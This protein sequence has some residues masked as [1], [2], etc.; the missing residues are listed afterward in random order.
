MSQSEVA[1]EGTDTVTL[2][3]S[4]RDSSLC[5]LFAEH[6]LRR[7]DALAVT[8][9]PVTLTYRQLDR[10]TNSLASALRELGVG[11]D[12]LVTI[13]ADRSLGVVVGM[14]ATVKAGGAYLAL[15]PTQPATRLR[16]ILEEAKPVAL[17]TEAGADD[18]SGIGTPVV[19]IADHL[20]DAVRD[21]AAHDVRIDGG[22]GP[23][24]L[25]YVVYTSGSTGKPKGICITHRNVVQRTRHTDYLTFAPGDRVAQVSNAAFDATTI[26]VWG[27]L[28]NGA[29]LIGF[30]RD[31]ILSPGRLGI[32]L[33]EHHI[34]TMVIPTPLFNQLAA[35]DPSTFATVS[36]I[37]VGG[38]VIGVGQANSVA[39]L[40]GC[41]LLNGYGPAECTTLATAHRV[42]PKPADQLRV[43]IG[44]PISNTTCYVLDDEL[45]P[46][47]AGLPGQLYI[48]GDGVARGYLGR[49]DLTKER[50]LPDP[51]AAQPGA[52][53]YATGDLV[54]QL[55]DGSLDFLGRA[56]F[57]VKI[58]GFRVEMNEV[59]AT[60]LLHPG[61][62]E[63]VTVAD[64]DTQSGD[65][66]LV[67]YYVGA[68]AASPEMDDLKAFLRD[69][70]PDYMV[71]SRLICLPELPKNSNMKVD[72]AQLPS[73]AVSSSAADD[74][75]G[76]AAP[77]TLDDEI[78][79]IIGR[80]LDVPS[81][82]REENF[83][84]GG[85]QSMLAIRLLTQVGRR[86]GVNMTLAEFFEDPTARGIASY[87]RAADPSSSDAPVSGAAAR[88]GEGRS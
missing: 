36:Q 27:A 45:R 84:E 69:R 39:A 48:A 80:L 31:T 72:R 71:P 51:F 63:A 22:A 50:F 59:D 16:T 68:D 65:K 88:P 52:R 42:T 44:R 29:E 34:D 61:V 64:T 18:P 70:L 21:G 53:M 2:A 4:D 56:D 87:I 33:R 32:A 74:D 15:D 86:Y 40:P 20:A 12:R 24:D 5:D 76:P 37:L 58:R 83:F 28:L 10:V 8:Y 82:G 85:G 81:F 6:V 38:D 3:P 62:G 73:P 13:L 60:L 55:P 49:P 30:D 9:G 79:T 17:L 25:A 47:Q 41:T 66:T 35:D 78:T 46:Q 57:Q 14:L 7:P 54:C 1:I 19:T 43:P 77:E 67:S 26:E 23:E 75:A 11:T